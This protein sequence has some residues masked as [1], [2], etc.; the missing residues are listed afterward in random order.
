MLALTAD[1]RID[2]RPELLRTLR[3]GDSDVPDSELILA[4]YEKWGEDLAAHLVG[5]FAFA[6]W[7]GHARKLVCARDVMGIK[8]FYY[9]AGGEVFAFASEI[10]GLLAHPEV[11]RRLNETKVVDY[12]A[13]V[14]EDLEQTFYEGIYRLPP[15]QVL[16]VEEGRIRRRTYWELDASRELRLGSDEAYVE[17]FREVFTEALRGVRIA[18]HSDE[19]VESG[20]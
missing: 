15:A 2:N 16:V 20:S 8:P 3:L 1:A 10:K 11:P 17:A 5:D 18:P 6:L 14:F 4:A 7:D 9:Y 19:A 13:P 12:L